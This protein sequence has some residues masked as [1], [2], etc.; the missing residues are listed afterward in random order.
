[1]AQGACLQH[2]CTCSL[3]CTGSDMHNAA[4]ACSVSTCC[5]CSGLGTLCLHVL[6]QLAL[7]GY[8]LDV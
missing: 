8:L 1:M 7:V 4:L 6:Y 3:A 5:L 2:A